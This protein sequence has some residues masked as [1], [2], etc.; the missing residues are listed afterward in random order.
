VIDIVAMPRVED[1]QK[2]AGRKK[3]RR[4]RRKRTQDFIEN[5]N[6]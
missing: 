4:E 2:G 1:A 6:D 3:G 5:K